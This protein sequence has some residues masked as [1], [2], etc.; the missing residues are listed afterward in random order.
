L[1]I[2]RVIPISK[3]RMSRK[4]SPPETTDKVVPFERRRADNRARQM[5]GFKIPPHPADESIDQR[6]EGGERNAGGEQPD[7]FRHRMMANVVTV[8]IVVLLI[9]CGLWLADEMASLRKTQDCVLSG[10]RNCAPITLP[11]HKR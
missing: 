4:P 10:R 3:F 9:W 7:D 1:R 11:D 2:A 5:H 6:D 8:V